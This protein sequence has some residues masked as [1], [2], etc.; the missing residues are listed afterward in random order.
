MATQKRVFVD[1]SSDNLVP[2]GIEVDELGV[3][4]DC[5]FEFEPPERGEREW[6]TG[7]Q[8]EPDYPATF[9]LAHAYL[10]G[11][12]VDIAPVMGREVIER[13]EEAAYDDWANGDE[14]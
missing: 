5:W 4:L 12:D 11:S 6:G 1:H 14:R 3:Q 13:L 2:Y 8:L 9:A 7:L 10:P